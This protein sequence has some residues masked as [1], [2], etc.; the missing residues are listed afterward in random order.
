LLPDEASALRA[1]QAACAERLIDERERCLWEL[2]GVL[3]QV[4]G[5][6]EGCD[7]VGGLGV[8][9]EPGWV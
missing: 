6:V 5:G 9:V 2:P 4:V 7:E 8:D 1:R 3:A